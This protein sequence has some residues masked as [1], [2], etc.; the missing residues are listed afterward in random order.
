MEYMFDVTPDVLDTPPKVFSGVIRMKRNANKDLECD[1]SVF[2]TVVKQG[3]QNRRKTLR[4]ALKPLSLPVKISELEI[5]NRRAETLS[6][7]EFIGL[8]KLVE[9]WKN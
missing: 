3:F 4:N 1:Y 8:A 2:K 7:Q 6:Y 5:L 9:R